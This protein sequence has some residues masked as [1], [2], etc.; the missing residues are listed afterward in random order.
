MERFIE[1]EAA[2]LRLGAGQVFT[3][4]G[5]LAVAKGLL[6]SGVSYIGGYPG[7]RASRLLDAF[8]GA[9]GLL[10]ELG[11][12]FEISANEAGACAMLG[13]SINYP[14]RGA[15]VWRSVAGLNVAADALSHLSSAGVTGGALIVLGEDYG[16]RAAGAQERSHAF[17]RKSQ[18][19]L[20]DPRPNPAVIAHMAEKGFELSEASN[21]PV[22]LA[23]RPGACHVHGRFEAK[24]NIAPKYSRHNPLP[25]PVFNPARMPL[26]P[27]GQAQEK[28]K[29]ETRLPA[30]LKFIKREQ[31][32]E[33]FE[34]DLR[35][36][37]I[38][39][40]GGLYNH[41]IRAL[42]EL[43]LADA[44]G[45]SRIPLCVL[46]V[47]WPL[48]S[49]EITRFCSNKRAVLVVEE[50]QPAHLEEAINVILRR[51]DI[52]D[53]HLVGKDVLPAAGEYTPEVVLK[54]IGE[55]LKL[56]M[57]DGVDL[58]QVDAALDALAGAKERAAGLLGALL[59]PRS[60]TFCVGC[61]AW[62]V[63][64]ALKLIEKES[65]G[66]HISVD[67]GCHSLAALPP[68]NL[69]NTLLGYGLSLPAAAAVGP[70]LGRRVV[71]VMDAGGFWY[72]GLATGVADAVSRGEDGVLVIMQSGCAADGQKLPSKPLATALAIESALRGLGVKWLE[73]VNSYRVADVADALRRAMAAPE[74]GL[75]VLIA[76]DERVHEHA[77]HVRL[78]IDEDICTGD[79][80]CIR[81]S[82]CPSLTIKDSP[83]PLRAGP[84]TTI[85]ASCVGCGA[86]GE[87]AQA[88]GLCPSFYRVEVIEN[89]G[90]RDRVL[91][92]IRQ[93]I[94]GLFGGGR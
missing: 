72:Q 23:L 77:T 67:S 36:A 62:P 17:A 12:H 44:A 14:L 3:G 78:G 45:A 7:G 46:N 55:F 65:G 64:S 25:K 19:W 13:A 71:A 73:R 29:I 52:N 30:A 28:H 83:D 81:L 39:M 92:G 18:V 70:N 38:I 6:Q 22:M 89:P 32:N 54:G 88:A 74:P 4:E 82:G 91:H 10:D 50:G 94:I 31:L 93:S 49:E 16:E 69:G 27:H 86:C 33:F 90:G 56:I 37:G 47:T 41:V 42:R 20:L 84:A 5:A 85:D 80:T 35:Q 2:Q 15:A 8:A 66:I 11:V 40:Q 21:T 53:P 24:N 43:G 26:P 34:G 57:L 1:A 68:F 9:R 58:K 63:F 59:P 61:P 87:T 51:A 76:D 75:K 48:V 79:R 60:P